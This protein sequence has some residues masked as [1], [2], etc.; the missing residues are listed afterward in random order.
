MRN[1]HNAVFDVIDGSITDSTVRVG[2]GAS[3]YGFVGRWVPRS[4]V[5]WMIGI[6]KVDQL[7]TWN[8][9]SYEGSSR[10]ESED[11]EASHEFVALPTES[12]VWNGEAESNVN[13]WMSSP[14]R[15]RE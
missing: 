3:V 15:R 4:L 13:V 10:D 1:L 2:L 12:T 9:S 5:A 6:R 8:T 11:G 14:P 7:S